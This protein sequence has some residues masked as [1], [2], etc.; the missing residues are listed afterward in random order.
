M[1]LN[2][3]I[4]RLNLNYKVRCHLIIIGMCINV[5]NVEIYRLNLN[6]KVRFH[7]I[8]IDMCIIVAKC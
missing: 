7:L 4:Y 6:Y 3:E 5:D 1:L 2:V 8:I